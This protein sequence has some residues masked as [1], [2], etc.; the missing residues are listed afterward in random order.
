[1]PRSDEVDAPDRHERILAVLGAWLESASAL[2]ALG[3]VECLEGAPALLEQ[4]ARWIAEL[5]GEA[6]AQG[7]GRAEPVAV[8]EELA[9]GLREAEQALEARLAGVVEALREKLGQ[10][11][12]SRRANEGYRPQRERVPAFVSRQI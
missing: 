5:E 1:M 9:K 7:D 11:H 4:R 10:V 8:P 2:S 3:D 12:A 6:E